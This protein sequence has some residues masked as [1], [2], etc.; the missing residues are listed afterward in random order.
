[1]I[2]ITLRDQPLMLE[3]HLSLSAVLHQ[4]EIKGEH[5]AVAINLTFVP[6]SD[7]DKTFFKEGDVVDIILPMQ[8]G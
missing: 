3:K 1:M 7:Y 2:K 8:G 6:R 5:F 4:H